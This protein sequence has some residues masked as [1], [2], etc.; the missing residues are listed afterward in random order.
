VIDP[1]NP[2]NVYA[3]IET[4][5]VHRSTDGGNTWEAITFPGILPLPN[6]MGRQSLA[7]SASSPGTVYAMLGNRAGTGYVGFFRSV[8]GGAHWTAGAV[9]TTT[10][11]TT[12]ID[13]MDGFAQSAYDQVL[14][15]L[16]DNPDKIYFGGVGPY[17]S[18]DAGLTWKFLAG[19]VGATA[20]STH[21]DQHTV[22]VDPFN[23][24]YLYVGNDGGFYR[25]QID[26]DVWTALSFGFSA[27]QIQAL[28]DRIHRTTR[29]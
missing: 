27:G 9:P 4:D 14:T 5:T 7:I 18:T 2:N 20:T 16:P 8:D 3:A 10:L 13:G 25:Y 12:V 28:T 15:V 22:A 1:K 19:G 11:D 17:M 29:S 21:A 26:K 23:S 6:Q 24:D